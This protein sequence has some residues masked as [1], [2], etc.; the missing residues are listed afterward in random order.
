MGR[1]NGGWVRQSKR[2][3][4]ENAEKSPFLSFSTVPIYGGTICFFASAALC[5]LCALY[6][7]RA[8]V[9]RSDFVAVVTF[10]FGSFSFV[11]SGGNVDNFAGWA[12]CRMSFH[13]ALWE[14]RTRGGGVLRPGRQ[15]PVAEI[16]PASC[17]CGFRKDRTLS[18]VPSR[19]PQDGSGNR[20]QPRG[21]YHE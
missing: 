4:A 10:L 18:G 6:V 9:V 19:I 5:G 2:K 3:G 14:D 8:A 20:T 7:K 13:K 1:R 21:L 16:G 11:D 17:P 12:L 15:K